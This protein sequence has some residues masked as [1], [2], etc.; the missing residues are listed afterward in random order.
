[1]KLL[2]V[3][4]RLELRL[5]LRSLGFWFYA[6]SYFL[7]AMAP[8]VALE[9]AR[10]FTTDP[11]NVAAYAGRL[12]LA[13]PFLTFLFATG[14]S[15]EAIQRERDEGS[16]VVLGL[17]PMTNAGY[18]LRRWLA[19]LAVIL[20][21]TLAPVVGTAV[22]AAARGQASPDPWLFLGPWL[23]HVLPLAVMS[24]ALSL[25]LGTV[26]RGVVPASILGFLV[27]VL[28]MSLGNDLLARIGRRI[29]GPGSWLGFSEL[30][31]AWNLSMAGQRVTG[32]ASD[33]PYDLAA[34]AEIFT[35]RSLMFAALAVVVVGGAVLLLGRTRPDVRPWRIRDNHPLRG[36]LR[37]L[38]RLREMFVPEPGADW[39]DRLVGMAGLLVLTG[40]VWLYVDRDDRYRALAEERYVAESSGLPEPTSSSV[41]PRSWKIEGRLTRD[42][43]LSTLTRASFENRGTESVEHLAFAL[44]PGL[45]LVA[46]WAD[47]GEVA[48]EIVWDRVSLRID[49]PLVSRVRWISSWNAPHRSCSALPS[50]RSRKADS[51]AFARAPYSKRTASLVGKCRKNVRRATPARSAISSTV[52]PSK[53]RLPKSST[54]AS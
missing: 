46:A 39:R 44:D 13:L 11:V 26:A 32:P 1:M 36:T 7:V 51:S 25:G 29:D 30:L 2:L 6:V 52:V 40:S 35:S 17:A 43:R 19:V 42:G 14:I 9:V 12:H 3:F 4:V 16:F 24:S 20:P 50:A 34:A 53:P 23:L 41:V 31:Y 33:A 45:S 21:W 15:V 54:A 22:L 5:S 48:A 37:L 18:V 38:S 8:V 28:V 49:P 47:R 27:F 10:H